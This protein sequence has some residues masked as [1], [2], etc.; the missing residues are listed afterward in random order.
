M[1][2]TESKIATTEHLVQ[3]HGPL[4]GVVDIKPPTSAP[5]IGKDILFIS[6]ATILI[7]AAMIVLF[8]KPIKRL[9]RGNIFNKRKKV[10]TAFLNAQSELKEL[11]NTF[12]SDTKIPVKVFSEKLIKILKKYLSTYVSLEI[13]AKTSHEIS[14]QVNK[15]LENKLR[16]AQ[17]TKMTELE[18]GIKDVFIQLEEIEY[19]PEISD[20]RNINELQLIEKV[21]TIIQELEHEDK[22]ASNIKSTN[23]NKIK[24]SKN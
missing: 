14:I 24:S 23:K 7:L 20:S 3:K 16:F 4:E 2:D 9:L 13:T 6:I 11:K 5:L 18:L 21:Q 10:L 22:L 17:K 12:N 15:L 19:R 1:A 8:R